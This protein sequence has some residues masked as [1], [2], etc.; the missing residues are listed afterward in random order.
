MISCPPRIFFCSLFFTVAVASVFG[1]GDT[2]FTQ[3]HLDIFE[4][5]GVIE[6]DGQLDDSGW[7]NVKQHGEFWEQAPE[8]GR[9][10][11]LSTKVMVAYS[12]D[13]IY[14]AAILKDPDGQIVTTLKRDNMGGNDSFI[15]VIDPVN[16][17][18]NGFAFGVNTYGAQTEILLSPTNGDDSWD[19]RWRSATQ[20][21][22]DGWNVEMFI[23][24]SSLRFDKN[25]KTWG[26]NFVRLD[27]GS[28][29]SHV[30]SPV[31]RQFDAADMGYY[32]QMHWDKAPS[33]KKGNISL[34]PYVNANTR[35]DFNSGNGAKTE[36]N[37]GGEMPKLDCQPG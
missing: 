11:S 27:Q 19:N 26:I 8:D 21:F 1:Q 4:V 5:R 12:N 33:G 16:Q 31:P 35:K 34:I 20:V 6:V 29:E 7:Q 14:V 2:T 23:P 30:W 9:P 13:G 3:K 10:A 37:A 36:I 32:G 18:S 28:N 17:K 22:D 15:V 25:N 24:F